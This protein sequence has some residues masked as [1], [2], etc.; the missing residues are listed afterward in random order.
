L[1]QRHFN[2][3]R[4]QAG[5]I[6]TT[7]AIVCDVY[8]I[9]MPLRLPEGM[10]EWLDRC[11]RLEITARASNKPLAKLLGTTVRTLPPEHLGLLYL[12]LP[13]TLA[14]AGSQLVVTKERVR[15]IQADEE[16]KLK[17]AVEKELPDLLR[18]WRAQLAS[19]A[20]SESDLFDRHEDPALD[21]SLQRD[22]G[23][24][25]LSAIGASHPIYQAAHG[26][27]AGWWC[28]EPSRL[29]RIVRQARTIAPCE[30]SELASYATGC[31]LPTDF[32]IK[33][34]FGVQ[35]S[36]IRFDARVNGWV[37]ESANERDAVFL[38]LKQRHIVLLDELA[39]FLHVKPVRRL[40]AQLSGDSR[41]EKLRPSGEWTLATPGNG[42][43]ENT[44]RTTLDAVLSVLTD[45][46]P[47]KLRQL[48]A[49]VIKKYP[50]SASAVS[51]C[52]AS[53]FIGRWPDGRIDLA[54]RGAP[55]V[56]QSIPAMP[57]SIKVMSDELTLSLK[58]GKSLL[59]GSS[60][61]VHR[62]I[63][64]WLG[65]TV[66]PSEATFSL[67]DRQLLSV[68]R[69]L[70]GSYLSS[71]RSV[72][73]QQGASFGCVLLLTLNRSRGTAIIILTCPGHSHPSQVDA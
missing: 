54:Q 5:L 43:R 6:H 33:E 47:M 23:R 64:W 15:Q 70:Q 10:T 16:R 21:I 29:L 41:F 52:L 27:L 30:Q 50:V 20:V 12:R 19:P 72:A 60:V 59:R 1:S 55:R 38:Y 39:G 61:P 25:V 3:V 65:M 4:L 44:Y 7:N 49:E 57:A 51:Q 32:P 66:A 53:S 63:T 71:L 58:V 22:I 2:L 36:R 26:Q 40:D 31:S 24:I 9:L 13:S 8:Q 18:S 28:S 48:T 35:G 17:E 62:Y 73:S 67:P 56:R 34:V 11:Q 69:G 42:S 45:R 37:K 46:G 68:H 14:K